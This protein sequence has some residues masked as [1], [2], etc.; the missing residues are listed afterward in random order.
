MR[1]HECFKSFCENWQ[2]NR[3]YGHLCYVAPL[4]NK[5]LK[6]DKV[7]FVCYDFETTQDRRISDTA[8]LHVPNLVCLQQFCPQCE[9]QAD[10]DT[11]CARCGRRIT[12]SGE[13]PWATCYL[14]CVNRD[15]GA[16]ESSQSHIMRE[17]SMPN[18]CVRETS[19]SMDP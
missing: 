4:V 18:S 3:G 15:R 12:R 9:K 13:N 17:A 6:S 1:T 11:D 8:T 16:K 19:C 10:I 14:I 2:K 5:L 7:L